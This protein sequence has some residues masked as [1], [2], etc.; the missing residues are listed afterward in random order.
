MSYRSVLIVDDDQ[1]VQ[2]MLSFLFLKKGF[3]VVSAKDGIDAL[4]IL[5]ILRP[6]IILMDLAMPVMDGFELCKRIKEEMP[7]RDIPIIVISALSVS[8]SR[9]RILSLGVREFFEKP[10]EIAHLMDRVNELLVTNEDMFSRD[11]D[12]L[13]F[14]GGVL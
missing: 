10:F 7:I 9:E 5:T 4:K 6:D 8:D 2:K 3:K 13:N 14:K 12:G 11:L 1:R